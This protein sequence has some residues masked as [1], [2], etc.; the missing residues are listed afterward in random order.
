MVTVEEWSTV[1]QRSPNWREDDDEGEQQKQTDED[2]EMATAE[3][4]KAD[5]R[6]LTCIHTLYYRLKM[7]KISPSVRQKVHKSTNK[8]SIHP[9]SLLSFSGTSTREHAS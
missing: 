3:G 7:C 4:K 6:R 9:K 8:N 1:L 2:F 5:I